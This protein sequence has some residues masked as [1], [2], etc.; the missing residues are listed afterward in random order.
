M[1]TTTIDPYKVAPLCRGQINNDTSFTGGIPVLDSNKTF[2]ST[3]T[4][5]T[6]PPSFMAIQTQ[7]ISN[8]MKIESGAKKAPSTIFSSTMDTA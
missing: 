2:T 3:T 6:G 1:L 5:S 8:M 4:T 7:N